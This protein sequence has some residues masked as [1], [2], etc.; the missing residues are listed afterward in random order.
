VTG[1]TAVEALRLQTL[2]AGWNPVPVSPADKSCH[3]T[4]WPTIE[5][6]AFHIKNWSITNPA[7]S[8]TGL[9][10]N[11]NYFAVDGDTLDK[12]LADRLMVTAF[13]H[14]GPTPFIR[15][16][17][18]PKFLL[19]YQKETPTSVRSEGYKFEGRSN[20]GLEILSD[21][22]IF[23]AFG[24]HPETQRDYI[25][26]GDCNPLDDTPADAPLIK[27]DQVDAFL[28]AVRAFAPFA[29]NK[30][31]NPDASRQYNA[32]GEVTD[33]RENFL[34]DCVYQ[35]ACEMWRAG[36][37]L[38][39]RGVAARGWEQFLQKAWTDDGKWTERHA[40][41]KAG[42]TV[43][44][45][46]DGI[47]KLGDTELPKTMYYHY[48]DGTASEIDLARALARVDFIDMRTI[49]F[50]PMEHIDARF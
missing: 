15:V 14:L 48:V 46:R 47:L 23:T 49:A 41:A 35:A 18:A 44:R 40:L 3:I 13:Q 27:Q 36:E 34:R 24:T 25:W 8:N 5:T 45:V 42:S 32:S 37:P 9:V 38:N 39:A 17:R 2:D 30:G 28:G 19:V 43:R 29:P 7:H 16:G 12:P 1:A 26:I 10:C 21:K 20:E 33:G 31:G 6:T 22:K 4:G 50:P 11:R